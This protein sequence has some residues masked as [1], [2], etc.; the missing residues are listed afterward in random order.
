MGCGAMINRFVCWEAVIAVGCLLAGCYTDFGPVV[1]D[2]A[3]I[4]AATV[5]PQFEAGDRVSVTVYDEPNLTGVYDVNPSGVV[6]LPL[7]GSVRAAG[8]TRDQL[9]AAITDRYS[10]G[11]FLDDPHVTVDVVQFRPIYILGEVEK[12]GAYPYTP[13]LNALTAVT[14]AGGLT[15]RGSTSTVLIERAGQQEWTQYP[16]LASVVVLPG[17]LIRIPERYF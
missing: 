16:L 13:G 2:P 1:A 11:K 17:D 10:D 12:P 9:E 15:Y 8:R 5:T 3:P 4:A 7:I 14:A 6:V